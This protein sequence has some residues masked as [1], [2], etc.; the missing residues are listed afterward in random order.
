MAPV[1]RCLNSLPFAVLNTMIKNA[2]ERKAYFYLANKSW[3]LIIE[4]SQG[5]S[6]SGIRDKYHGGML[7]VDLLTVACSAWFLLLPRT[8]CPGV[9]PPTVGWALSHWS[10]I[11]KMLPQICSPVFPL[12][13]VVLVYVKSQPAH[14][15]IKNG[16]SFVFMKSFLSA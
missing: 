11:E 10:L 8:S 16:G 5:R 7:L 2:L 9:E 6:S 15:R 4:R 13:R 3:E 14:K 1:I 12:S